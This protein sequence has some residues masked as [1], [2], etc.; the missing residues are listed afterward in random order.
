LKVLTSKPI[1]NDIVLFPED[2][3]PALRAPVN[4]QVSWIHPVS[5]IASD[6]E[7]KVAYGFSHFAEAINKAPEAASSL[8]ND[9]CLVEFEHDGVKSRRFTALIGWKSVEEHYR[10]KETA[11][12]MD[13]V[14]WLRGNDH[15]GVEM[16]HY[17]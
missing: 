13:N 7:K 3:R 10:C 6:C 14:H 5:K 16:A 17:K 15:S 8:V 12:F 11:L 9:W 4:E 1:Y 2:A